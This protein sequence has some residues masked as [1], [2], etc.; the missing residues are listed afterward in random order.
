MAKRQFPDIAKVT[1][2]GHMPRGRAGRFYS[3]GGQYQSIMKYSKNQQ[4]AKEFLRWFMDRKQYDPWFVAN[5]GYV[6]G[7]TPHWEKHDMWE[8][9]LK[10]VPFKE[11][12]RFGRWPGY[13]GPPSRKASEALVKYVLVD[14]YAQAINGMKPEDAARWAETELKKIYA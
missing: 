7:P 8:R 5:D 4:V 2:H 3:I 14:M 11:S 13:P 1:G 9:D 6:N 10:L 12:V